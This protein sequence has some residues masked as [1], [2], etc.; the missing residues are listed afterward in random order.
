MYYPP[1]SGCKSCKLF[2]WIL[3]SSLPHLYDAISTQIPIMDREVLRNILR[4][5]EGAP[6]RG[7]PMMFLYKE[8][9]STGKN[10]KSLAWK[11][12][13][14]GYF[15]LSLG[16]FRLSIAWI[17]LALAWIRLAL[18]YIRLPLVWIRLA[19]TYIRLALSWIR[20]PI[21]YFPPTIANKKDISGIN[22]DHGR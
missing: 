22:K 9:I 19:L 20:L 2:H 14:L 12:L 15:R 16:Y 1:S 18:D 21:V 4:G 3:S 10:W 8:L 7:A 5:A 13:S 17:R 6:D 11:R